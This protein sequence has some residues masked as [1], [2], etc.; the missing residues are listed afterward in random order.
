MMSYKK[1]KSKYQIFNIK[2]IKGYPLKD[3]PNKVN[4]SNFITTEHA[5]S[6]K[7]TIDND[8]KNKIRSI[9]DSILFNKK[10]NSPVII[11]TGAHLIKNGLG[12]LIIDLIKKGLITL[13]SGNGATAIHDFELALIGETSENVPDCLSQGRFGMADDFKFINEILRL[14]NN[15]NL[16]LGE[17]IG[18][19]M[20]N[21]EFRN[22]VLKKMD[23]GLSFKKFKFIEF[24]IAAHCYSKKIPFT[25]HVGIGTD[26]IDQQANFSGEAKG[27]CSARD[28]LIFANEITKFKKG[29]IFLNIG[30]AIMG[31]EVFLKAVSMA[32]NVCGNIKNITT[33]NFDLRR[34]NPVNSEAVEFTEYYYYRDQKSIVNRIPKA[35]NGKG[36][37]ISGDQRQTVPFLYK[38]II[39][40][41]KEEK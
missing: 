3:R 35:F 34:Q 40:N 21:P 2:N 14:G 32:S 17:A 11:F 36:Y 27:G 38:S 18:K 4:I 16:G 19:T 9:A 7:F 6:M 31:P 1:Y 29:G 26:V 12:L 8:I 15:Y 28:F 20:N 39:E 13:I 5:K 41:Y 23:S 37:H 10:N 33:A 25:V 30:S 24:S 22:D